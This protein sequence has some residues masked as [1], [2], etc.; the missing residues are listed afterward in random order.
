MAVRV[1][2]DQLVA[3]AR[4]LLEPGLEDR[5]DGLAERIAGGLLDR[6]SVE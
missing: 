5:V 6:A 3:L 4:M 2:D 1:P